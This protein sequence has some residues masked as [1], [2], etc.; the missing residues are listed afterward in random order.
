MVAGL[1]ILDALPPIVGVLVGDQFAER[2][3]VVA[4]RLVERGPDVRH[5]VQPAYG[6]HAQPGALCDRIVS[7]APSTRIVLISSYDRDDLARLIAHS[8]AVGVLPKSEL[9]AAA[10]ERLIS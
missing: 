2:P 9:G 10:S 1:S 5:H 6:T 7:R 3:G 8:P 4:D